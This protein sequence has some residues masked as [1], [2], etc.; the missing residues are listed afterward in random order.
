MLTLA[1]ALQALD[2][3]WNAKPSQMALTWN[4]PVQFDTELVPRLVSAYAALNSRFEA[5]MH[6]FN[7]DPEI[8]AAQVMSCAEELHRLRHTEALRL[9]P[10]IASGLSADPVAR[11]VFWQTRI[12]MLGLAR[13]VFRRFD[14]LVRAIRQQAGVATAAEHAVTALA[15]Y[16][17]RNEAEIYPLYRLSRR[18]ES[19]TAGPSAA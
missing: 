12:V 1:R 17:Q 14:E 2:D 3:V 6:R 8:A 4:P 5:L 7:A 19:A 16:R 11:R 18:R 9:Y 15:E 13:R 10:V